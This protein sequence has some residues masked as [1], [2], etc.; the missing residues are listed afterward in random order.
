M[1]YLKFFLN[2]LPPQFVNIK[3][4]LPLKHCIRSGKILMFIGQKMILSDITDTSLVVYEITFFKK[5]NKTFFVTDLCMTILCFCIFNVVFKPHTKAYEKS[6]PI[7][8]MS[9]I[10][11]AEDSKLN[12]L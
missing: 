6:M 2:E 8:Q 11:T 9:Y 10:T 4:S 7:A 12:L 5:Q 1:F 3:I